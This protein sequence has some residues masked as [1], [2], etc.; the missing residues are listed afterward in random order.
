[1]INAGMIALFA[2]PFSGQ[3]TK[4]TLTLPSMISLAAA[5][6]HISKVY[7]PLESG[8]SDDNLADFD[9]RMI[10]LNGKVPA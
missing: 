8:E 4:P 5:S 2:I 10:S 3:L 6:A 9:D 1:M 7:E